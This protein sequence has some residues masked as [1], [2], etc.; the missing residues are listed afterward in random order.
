LAGAE[1]VAGDV[2]AV[3]IDF[4][5]LCFVIVGNCGESGFIGG[6]ALGLKPAEFGGAFVEQAMGLSAGAVYRLLDLVGLEVVGFHGIENAGGVG[7][8][9]NHHEVGL[10]LTAA[11][12]T[13]HGAADF[14]DESVF[15][16]GPGRVIFEKRVAEAGVIGFFTGPDEISRGEEAVGDGVFGARGFAFVS[17]RACGGLRVQDVCVRMSTLVGSLFR[18]SRYLREDAGAIL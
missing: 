16:D 9:E 6:S 17:A 8:A 2:W 5:R 12:E 18:R 4:D 15:E 1:G 14:V 10:Y 13:P 3:R 11:A 7:A